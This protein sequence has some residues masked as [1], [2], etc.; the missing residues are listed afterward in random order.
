MNTPSTQRFAGWAVLVSLGWLSFLLFEGFAP[1]FFFAA[2][3]VAM[4]RK[5]LHRIVPQ[6]ELLWGACV[7]AAFIAV[8]IAS[9]F[10]TPASAGRTLERFCR[11]PAVII[12]LWL[13]CLWLGF[14]GWRRRV[15][16]GA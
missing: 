10:L 3:F 4:P 11:H 7:L 13:L 5:E 6:R 16:N 1:L 9:K 15:D 2:W 8:L 14:K 12:I